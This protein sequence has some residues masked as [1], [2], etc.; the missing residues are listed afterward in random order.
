MFNN[1]L[2]ILFK[3]PISPPGCCSTKDI[4]HMIHKP[5]S[6]VAIILVDF[7][8]DGTLIVFALII[9]ILINRQV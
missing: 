1:R 7:Q 2:R 9:S 5:I 6:N 4:V 3:F 8:S